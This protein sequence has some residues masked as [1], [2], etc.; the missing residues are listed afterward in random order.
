M[1]CYRTA[2]FVRDGD[3]VGEARKRGTEMRT[4]MNIRRLI[5]SVIPTPIHPITTPLPSLPHNPK[6]PPPIRPHP[7]V[8]TPHPSRPQQP[9]DLHPS[10]QT[11]NQPTAPALAPRRSRTLGWPRNDAWSSAAA[12]IE[13]VSEPIV[14]CITPLNRTA[15]E[16]AGA[17]SMA[18]LPGTPRGE[19][20]MFCS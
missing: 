14:K 11:A 15:G 12:G 13:R 4:S 10:P 9:Y 17:L 18:T 16:P 1:W 19:G 3:H 20:G 6:P 5:D 2:V 8:Q 7:P